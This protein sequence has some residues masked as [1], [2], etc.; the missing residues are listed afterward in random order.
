MHH[1]PHRH[2]LN[3][4]NAWLYWLAA[5]QYTSSFIYTLPTSFFGLTTILL[6]SFSSLVLFVSVYLIPSSFSI[7]LIVSYHEGLLVSH[8][9]CPDIAGV[10]FLDHVVFTFLPLPFSSTYQSLQVPSSFYL[11][12]TFPISL[13]PLVYQWSSGLLFS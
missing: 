8:V 2:H 13:A 4:H 5:P 7:H 10:F 9:V 12:Y 3:P 6:A 1:H 11:L